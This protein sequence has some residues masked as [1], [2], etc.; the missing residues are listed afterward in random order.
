MRFCSRSSLSVKVAF[1]LGRLVQHAALLFKS[2]GT[3]S[4]HAMILLA[5]VG[6]QLLERVI[7]KSKFVFESFRLICS[8]CLGNL[9][10]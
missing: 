7:L 3:D 4:G 9:R 1:A 8:L 10:N 6:A 2:K 5:Y